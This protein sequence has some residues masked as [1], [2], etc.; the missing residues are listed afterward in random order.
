MMHHHSL[1]SASRAMYTI[2][3]FL[4]EILWDEFGDFM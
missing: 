2:L 1:L 3:T 4:F